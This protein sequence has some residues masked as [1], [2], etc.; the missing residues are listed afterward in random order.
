MNKRWKFNKESVC[1][2]HFL[3]SFHVI[4]HQCSTLYTSGDI[5]SGGGGSS[6]GWKA[7]YVTDSGRG[8]GTGG[9]SAGVFSGP[10][11]YGDDDDQTEHLYGETTRLRYILE[12][13]R[14]S[15]REFLYFVSILTE[16]LFFEHVS[17]R[18]ECLMLSC[19][20]VFVPTQVVPGVVAVWHERCTGWACVSSE[21]SRASNQRSRVDRC[22]LACV[23]R[24]NPV[25]LRPRRRGERLKLVVL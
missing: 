6:G 1:G 17:C 7:A 8:L 12:H 5:G 11:G 10:G 3:K 16:F 24:R 22:Y 19:Q 18:L 4:C 23:P 25:A 14:S 9:S 13:W 2:M 20:I 21:P 15:W